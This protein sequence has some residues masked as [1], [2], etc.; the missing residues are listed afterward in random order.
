MKVRAGINISR[1][2][3][4]QVCK[5]CDSEKDSDDEYGFGPPSDDATFQFPHHPT[6][7]LHLIVWPVLGGGVVIVLLV[8]STFSC[9]YIRKRVRTHRQSYIYD[10]LPTTPT[11]TEMDDREKDT[12]FLVASTEEDAV[13]MR[14][15]R[16]LCHVLGDHGLKPVYYE[17]A[18]DH[19]ADSP[20]AL[21]MNQWVEL[22]F[23][24]CEF[25]LFVCTTK[26]LE[27]WNG[28]RRDILS[29]LV[30]PCRH[31][32]DGSLT[33]PQNI[34][35]LAVLFMGNRHN[36]PPVMGR[37]RQFDV[38][39]MGSEDIH[40]DSLIHYLLEVPRFAPPRI[41]N[42]FRNFV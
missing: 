35:R 11:E 19:S 42:F 31:L 17:Y 33:R 7:D 36:V 40:A 10:H 30:Y 2:D 3:L 8:F 37:F 39:R 21:G 13:M 12:V 34:S 16:H 18:Y 22:Q 38:F 20:R 26:F 25:V 4:R 23:S 5:C 32:L 6:Y 24:R 15:I 29:P 41:V 1:D 14:K 9:C 28:E 27:E